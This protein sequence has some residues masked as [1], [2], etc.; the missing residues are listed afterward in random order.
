M[1][2]QV[3]NHSH[4]CVIMLQRWKSVMSQ[5]WNLVLLCIPAFSHESHFSEPKH[6]TDL[7]NEKFL[8]SLDGENKTLTLTVYLCS[9]YTQQKYYVY[10]FVLCMFCVCIGI[11]TYISFINKL[12]LDCFTNSLKLPFIPRGLKLTDWGQLIYGHDTV[13]V[14]SPSKLALLLCPYMMLGCLRWLCLCLEA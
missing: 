11:Y 1:Q 13:T 5:E 8:V 9:C 3:F 2:T 4:R 7:C 10:A 12:N 14:G 6:S